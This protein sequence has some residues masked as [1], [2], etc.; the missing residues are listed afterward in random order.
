MSVNGRVEAFQK[1]A[2]YGCGG[3][4]RSVVLTALAK[5]VDEKAAAKAE[6]FKGTHFVVCDTNPNIRRA[7]LDS[8]DFHDLFAQGRI[9]SE[10][11][12][13]R[14][15]FATGPQDVAGADLVDLA[16]PVDQYGRCATEIAPHISRDTLITDEGS[17]KESAIARAMGAFK[18]FF[19]DKTPAFVPYHIPY[20]NYPSKNGFLIHTE[21]GTPEAIKR[22]E[23][24]REGL[25]AEH[26]VHVTDSE[27]D[28]IYGTCSHLNYVSV[29]A[30]LHTDF[31]QRVGDTVHST[32]PGNWIRAMTSISKT[33]PD[34]WPGILIDK[35]GSQIS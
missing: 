26:F 1:I 7:V 34:I 8:K 21:Y 13:Q 2:V 6:V 20:H 28:V 11:I 33:S 9:T 18:A 27:H 14:V 19:G 22:I 17:V 3:I 5:P 12:N 15:T 32:D 29:G 30:L 35:R 31:M 4:G 24:F 10:I 23:A 16:V 25:G